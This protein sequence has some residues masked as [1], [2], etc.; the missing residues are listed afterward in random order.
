MKY[1]VKQLLVVIHENVWSPEYFSIP[2]TADKY[3]KCIYTDKIK[4]ADKFIQ[5]I[6]IALYTGLSKWYTRMGTSITAS[7][8]RSR[9]CVNK[10]IYVYNNVL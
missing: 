8:I 5:I 10:I 7:P 2:N 9:R 1:N 6:S 3:E 4:K